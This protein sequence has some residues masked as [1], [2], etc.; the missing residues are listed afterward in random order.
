M[1]HE[2]LA[3]KRQKAIEAMAREESPSGLRQ[4]VYDGA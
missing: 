4:P 3:L 1:E 2:A